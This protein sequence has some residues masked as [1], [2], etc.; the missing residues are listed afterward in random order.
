MPRQV[1]WFRIGAEGVA[2][3]VS[4]LL[5]FGIQAWWESMQ[6][7]QSERRALE[8]IHGDLLTDTIELA[9]SG[10]YAQGY[11]QSARWLTDRWDDPE[12]DLDSVA[13]ALGRLITE[14]DIRPQRAAYAGLRDTNGL[15]LIRDD[16]LRAATVR[17]FEGAQVNWTESVGEASSRRKTL[18][19][20]LSP[21][22]RWLGTPGDGEGRRVARV[23]LVSAWSEIQS[24][25]RVAFQLTATRAISARSGGMA[26]AAADANA[27]LRAMIESELA[28]R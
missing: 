1:P 9:A 21:H 17:Y 15:T 23:V 6:D 19:A 5:A 8:L 4:I 12:V 22:L 11:A 7:R 13:V 27:E 18:V 16:S 3:V 26:R 2:I 28:Q 20:L 10:L 14:Y 24:D 25:N